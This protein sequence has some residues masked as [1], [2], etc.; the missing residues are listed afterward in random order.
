MRTIRV[1]AMDLKVKLIEDEVVDYWAR[2]DHNSGT[3][4][5]ND[6]AQDDME[7]VTLWHEVLHSLLAQ[8]GNREHNE[9]QIEALGYGIV[10]VLK[11][12][13]FLRMNE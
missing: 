10:Q 7:M 8:A 6:A 3:I 11:D 4:T 12:N 9:E 1:G 5:L 2:L 13:E